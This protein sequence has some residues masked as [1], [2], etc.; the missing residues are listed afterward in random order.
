VPAGQ[1]RSDLQH[2]TDDEI[3]ARA[4]RVVHRR[5]LQHDVIGPH[6]VRHAG[7]RPPD[8]ERQDAHRD[9]QLDQ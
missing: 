6:D 8:D 2:V 3:H 1:T 9:Q 4:Q 5:R 7:Q